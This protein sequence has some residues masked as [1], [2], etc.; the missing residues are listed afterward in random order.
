MALF[1]FFAYAAYVVDE[2]FFSRHPWNYAWASHSAASPV[3]AVL[4]LVSY[5]IP[6]LWY[7]FTGKFR[8]DKTECQDDFYEDEEWVGESNEA[9]WYGKP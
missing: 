1:V 9:K 2:W 6:A 8:P 4:G 3:N 7:V 5:G